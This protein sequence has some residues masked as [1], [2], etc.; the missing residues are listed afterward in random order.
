[1][2]LCCRSWIP[3][4]K[5]CGVSWSIIPEQYCGQPCNAGLKLQSLSIRAVIE[6]LTMLRDIEE[7]FCL[8]AHIPRPH[9]CTDT[10]IKAMARLF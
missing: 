5:P 7:T 3:I 9:V 1:M 8:L 10:G 2:S 4:A 6:G